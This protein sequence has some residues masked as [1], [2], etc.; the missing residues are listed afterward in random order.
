MNA[1]NRIIKVLKAITLCFALFFLCTRVYDYGKAKYDDYQEEL[2]GTSSYHGTD[3]EVTVEKG[4]AARTVAEKL[5]DKG[6]IK[7][8]SAFTKRLSESGKRLQPGTYTLNTGMNTLQ[9]IETMSP[10]VEEAEPIDKLTIP[11]GFTIEL[12]AARVEDQGI[13]SASDFLNAVNSITSE[14]FPYLSEV[15]AGAN[16]KYKLQGFL[17]PAT[18]DI[19]EDTTAEDLVDMMLNAF[20]DYYSDDLR[21]IAESRGMSTYGVIVRASIIEREAKL[22]DERPI[23]AGVIQNRLDEGM[24]L[25]MCPTVLYA[26]TDGKYDKPQVLYEDLEIDSPYNTYLYEGL[27]VGPICNPG[28][29]SIRAA[30]S[31]A[32]HNF[33]FYHVGDPETGAHIFTETYEEHIDTQIIGGPNGIPEDAEDLD[34]DGMLDYNPDQETDESDGSDEEYSEE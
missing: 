19:Y 27:P 2:K 11:E 5:K 3:V 34:G 21:M 15:P 17:F 26:L 25:E 6:L 31:P 29:A 22:D 33:L 28:L 8:T 7:Y 30:V 9:M 23:I 13:C 20:E 16:V 18:Y 32:E 14:R 24:K 10:I 4:D 1:F 12:I